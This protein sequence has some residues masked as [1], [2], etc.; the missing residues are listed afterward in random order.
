MG[1]VAT[2]CSGQDTE[3]IRL[4]QSGADNYFRHNTSSELL[5]AMLLRL[6]SRSGASTPELASH[7]AAQEKAWALQE[8][9]WK[10]ISPE[11]TAIQLT[12][13][14]R[15]FLKVLLGNP[16]HRAT[17]GQLIEAVTQ[18]PEVVPPHIHARRLGVLVSRLRR[19]CGQSG[20]A[21]PVKSLHNWG[22][23]FT[24]LLHASA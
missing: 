13:T 23:M 8:Q 6:M 9:G 19:K 4:L 1:I 22:Y 17:H 16:E 12:T 10:L 15:A 24:E 14:E 7:F 11:G 18:G 21:L 2:V 20:L 3:A 5:T